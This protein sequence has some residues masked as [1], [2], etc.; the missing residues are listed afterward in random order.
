ML[1]VNPDP[2]PSKPRLEVSQT[3]A[4]PSDD[5]P[6]PPKPQNNQIQTPQDLLAVTDDPARLLGIIRNQ[7]EAVRIQQESLRTQQEAIRTQQE[8]IRTQQEAV[9][10]A[11]IEQQAR[12]AELQDYAKRL[13]AFRQKLDEMRTHFGP[14]PF[15]DE[16]ARPIL[17]LVEAK[18]ETT[19]KST[20]QFRDS[21]LIA[22]EDI[23]KKVTAQS[24]NFGNPDKKTT[25]QRS[26][27]GEPDMKTTTQPNAFGD[28]DKIT[29]TQRSILWDL[30]KITTTQ[31]S[32]LWDL[33]K[34]TTTQRS[35][36]GDLD[37]RTATQRLIPGDLDKQTITQRNALGELEK[38]KAAQHYIQNL[39]QADRPFNQYLTEFEAH[40]HDTGFDEQTQRLKFMEGL[41]GWLK[42]QI[43]IF[44]PSKM[45]FADLKK[46]CQRED[47]GQRQIHNACR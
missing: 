19:L 14:T 15:N 24:Y 33:R 16:Q 34:I 32:I 2:S 43:V 26:I 17:P 12:R 11:E 40:I 46:L 30:R 1:H 9:R 13:E 18:N 10:A 45:S 27:L 37:K 7:L 44:Q 36:L 41:S 4:K 42:F 35:V 6:Q 31:R 47:Y 23:D 22:N 38:K 20:A 5:P 21:H 28:P 39:R 29:T 25:T 3:N 8:A